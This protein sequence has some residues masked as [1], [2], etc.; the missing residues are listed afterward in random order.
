VKLTTIERMLGREIDF[1]KRGE[2]EQRD[3][4]G[5]GVEGEEVEGEKIEGEEIFQD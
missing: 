4:E 1:T 5:E 2:K 3:T